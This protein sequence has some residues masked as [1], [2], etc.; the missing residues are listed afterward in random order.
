MLE[1]FIRFIQNQSLDVSWSLRALMPDKV[2]DDLVSLPQRWGTRNGVAL[3][4]FSMLEPLQT[5][6]ILNAFVTTKTE[7]LFLRLHRQLTLARLTRL[8][9]YFLLYEFYLGGKTKGSRFTSTAWA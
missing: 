3:I 9:L 7:K 8:G 6:R 2:K 1:H 4:C 5:E